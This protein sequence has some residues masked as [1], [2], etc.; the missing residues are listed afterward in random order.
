M[1]FRSPITTPRLPY[2]SN[3]TGVPAVNPSPDQIRGNLALHICEPVRWRDSIDALAEHLPDAHFLEVG[4]RAVLYNMFGRGWNPGRRSKA[5]N[6]HN[7]RE[8]IKRL[9]AEL[10]H[11][12]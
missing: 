7:W 6:G 2:L 11:E 4:P 9:T 8:H 10:R 1:L 3:V 5:D 12:F